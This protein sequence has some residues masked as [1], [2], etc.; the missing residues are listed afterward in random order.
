MFP[1][2]VHSAPIPTVVALVTVTMMMWAM[3]SHK[4]GVQALKPKNKIGQKR[5]NLTQHLINELKPND[6]DRFG[7]WQYQDARSPPSPTG[8]GAPDVVADTGGRL[9]TAAHFRAATI[10]FSLAFFK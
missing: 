5:L 1:P 7:R 4:L 8:A 3:A 6:V 10:S 9:P 2:A